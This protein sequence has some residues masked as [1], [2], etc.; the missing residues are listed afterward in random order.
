MKNLKSLLAIALAAT[1]ATGC[2]TAYYGSAGSGFDDLYATHD[3]VAIANQQKAE[4]EARQAEAEARKAEWEAMLAEARGQG[5]RTK[6]HVGRERLGRL[7]CNRARGRPARELRRRQLRERLCA[8]SARLHLAHLPHAVELLQPALRR[9][10]HLRHGIRPAFYNIMVSGDE[11]WVEPKYITSMFGSWGATNVTAA[12]YSP[13]YV[14]WSVY[15]PWYYSWWG[16]PHYTWWD[17]NWNICYGWHWGFDFHWGWGGIYSPWYYP[18]W[19]G[20]YWGWGPHWGGHW[21]GPHWGDHW[22]GP[23]WGG[24]WNDGYRYRG[25]NYY[26]S[27]NNSTLGGRGNATGGSFVNRGSA[28]S[29][30]YRSPSSGNV[31]GGGS[32]GS[33]GNQSMTFDPGT[34]G[35]RVTGSVGVAAPRC[36]TSRPRAAAAT[37][38]P[39][40][41][42]TT[43]PR[44]SATT[45]SGAT[46][47]IRRT[48]ITRRS[49]ATRAA[50]DPSTRASR[51]A[52]ARA[53]VAASAAAE[54]A[55]HA[56][57]AARADASP[58][59]PQ[60]TRQRDCL[61][62]P[63]GRKE[64]H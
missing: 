15:D 59:A 28:Y 40:R 20:P 24:H 8:P 4:A 49:T 47:A 16:Y 41:C 64:N 43:T 12:I 39:R 60:R 22:G 32:R 27:R 23:H 55:D 46:T 17:W 6:I 33:R 11:V 54:A 50:A 53:A 57:E 3:R 26:G 14:G 42:A 13:W 44:A 29:T 25:G 7:A 38:R 10:V 2:T 34:S 31:Y 9:I 36:A 19:S 48:T 45:R 18:H 56:A 35:N 62:D 51:V 5:R 37:T 21:G 58:H 1:V 61:T 30:P 52:E 63:Q